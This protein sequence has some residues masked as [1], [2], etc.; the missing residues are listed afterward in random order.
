MPE[1]IN[2]EWREWCVSYRDAP[3]CSAQWFR[4]DDE[5]DMIYVTITRGTAT[6]F[7]LR[8]GDPRETPLE[9]RGVVLPS[10]LTQFRALY[11]QMME[12]RSEQLG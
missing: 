1:L 4:T 6:A 11:R 3:G 5:W 7:M 10:E 9:I 8:P 2:I 12:L